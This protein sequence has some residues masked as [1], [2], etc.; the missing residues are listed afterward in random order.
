MLIAATQRC[1][2]PTTALASSKV[3]IITEA[4]Q[5][6]ALTIFPDPIPVVRDMREL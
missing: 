5:R 2:T 6:G 3:L 1:G 4:Q